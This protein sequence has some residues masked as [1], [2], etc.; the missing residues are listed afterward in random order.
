MPQLALT[1]AF[2]AEY[3]QLDKPVRAGVLKA[4]AKFQS[5][6]PAQLGPDKGL[7][8]SAPVKA[9]DSRVRTIR[10]TAFWRGVVLAPD[11]GSDIYVLLKVL[12]HEDAMAWAVK[13]SF[14]VNAATHRLEARDVGAIDELQGTQPATAVPSPLFAEFSD[15]VLHELGVDEPTLKAVRAIAD[16]AQLEALGAF[17]PEDQYEVLQYLAEGFSADEVFRDLVAARRP[18]TPKGSDGR[19]LATAISDRGSRITLAPGSAEWEEIDGKLLVAPE[20]GELPARAM[21]GQRKAYRCERLPL[22]DGGQADVFKAVHKPSGR[23]VA[24]KKLRDKHPLPRQVARM[25]REI[26]L[27]RRLDGNPHAMPVLDCDPNN[28]WFV[29]PY[30]EATAEQCR[31]RFADVPALRSLLVGVCSAL[32]V[33]HRQGWVHRDIKPANVLLLNGRW[34][35]ADWGIVKRPAGLTTD[36]QRTRMGMFLGSDGFAAPESYSDA[37]AVG[38]SAD[39]YSLG[40]FI[41]WAVTGEYPMPNVPLLPKSGPWR[42]VVREATQ[43]EPARRPATV[44]DLLRLVGREIDEPQESPL[45]AGEYWRGELATGSPEAADQLVA[46]AGMK[47]DD[48]ELYC[49]LLIKIPLAPLL[50]ALLSDPARAVEMARSMAELLGSHRPPEPGEVDA[51]IGWLIALAQQAA[52]AGELDLLETCCGG[53]FDWGSAS[54]DWS[55][56]PSLATWISTLSGDAASSVASMLRQHPGFATH[57]APLA[58]DLRVDHRIRH[59]VSG[60]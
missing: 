25:A 7:G 48:A 28:T 3:E 5:L 17:L 27:G 12:P 36:A 40:Q 8:F 57:L 41:G 43:L 59:A 22:V 23:V 14:T 21:P 15:Q 10:I 11:D 18:A 39:I 37:H 58:H 35:L 29:M 47:S 30:A 16:R 13:R 31:D 54:E 53:A 49:D 9:R 51:V 42:S 55:P 56:P 6:T 24:L 4:V 2:R 34:L 50:P 32:T 38:P 46:L 1:T 44:E 60:P 26:E 19:T 33:A 45:V 52:T 20:L